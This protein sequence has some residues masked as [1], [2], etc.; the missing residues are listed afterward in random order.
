MTGGG[1]WKPRGTQGTKSVV[2]VVSDSTCYLLMLNEIEERKGVR[3]IGHVPV[4]DNKDE[5]FMENLG[6]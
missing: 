3:G 4:Q 2:V 6:K 1:V 5:G